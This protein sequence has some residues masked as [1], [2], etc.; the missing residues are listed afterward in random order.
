MRRMVLLSVLALVVLAKT[1][2]PAA[3]K[4]YPWCAYYDSST[5]NCGFYTFA[6]CMATITGIGGHCAINPRAYYGYRSYAPYVYETPVPY[7]RWYR[8]Y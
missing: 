7:K 5:Y 3:A 8:Y 1:G 2:G 6:Q 4:E